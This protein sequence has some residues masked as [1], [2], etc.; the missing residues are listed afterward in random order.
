MSEICR[1]GI[2]GT[3]NIARKNWQSIHNT[4]NGT[5]LAVAS[6][7]P[8]RAEQFI[9][10]CQSHVAFTPPPVACSYEALLANPAID[11]VYIPLPTG[12]RKEW[13]IKAAAAKKHVLCEKPCA[14]NASDLAEMIAACEKNQVQFMDG[15]MFM[16]SRRL[17]KLRETLNDGQSVGTLRRIASQFS[18]NAPEEFLTNNIR[19]SQALEPLGCLGDLGWYNTRLAL[20]IMNYQMPERVSGRILEANSEGVP[21]QFSAELFFPG[22][23]SA[24]F[25]NSFQTENQQWANLSGTK[26]FIHIPDFVLGYFDSEVA[27]TVTN[28][29]FE[30]RGC[31]FNMENHT[32]R[33]ALREYSNN[34]P[35]SQ[36]TNLFRNFGEIV[37]TKKLVPAWSEIALKTQR[38]LDALMASAHQQSVLVSV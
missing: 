19:V 11:A 9:A 35:N 25:Y 17:D 38:V 33:V 2:L 5:L 31:Q 20:W 18:F 14:V 1:W 8:A 7:T 15:V 22:G 27:F 6:R 29:H 21:L 13:V 24:S 4:G 30:T 26:G 16:H 36:E 28:A 12:L 34:M 3:A 23:V 32:Q 10:E 37:L